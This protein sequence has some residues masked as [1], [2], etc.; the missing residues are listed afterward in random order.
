MLPF[1]TLYRLPAEQKYS[2]RSPNAAV[3]LNEVMDLPH[4]EEFKQELR[5]KILKR[6]TFLP[7]VVPQKPA[8][9]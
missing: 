9:T 7:S 5:S 4:M 2:Y 1:M 8:E 3:D 6:I